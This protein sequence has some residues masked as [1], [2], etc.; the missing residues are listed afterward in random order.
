MVP[1]HKCQNQ[2]GQ[3]TYLQTVNILTCAQRSL[4]VL[5][6]LQFISKLVNNDELFKARISHP[7][8]RIN[9]D[10]RR[11]ATTSTD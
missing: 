1:A 5:N 8:I 4:H 9:F 2:N 6:I 11:G 10:Y 3:V 7:K